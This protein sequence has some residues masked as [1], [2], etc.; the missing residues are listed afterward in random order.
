MYKLRHNCLINKIARDK[1]KSGLGGG[2][3]E[4]FNLKSLSENYLQK[5]LSLSVLISLLGLAE[6][7]FSIWSFHDARHLNEIKVNRPHELRCLRFCV[8]K[9]LEEQIVT[10]TMWLGVYWI[11]CEIVAWLISSDLHWAN[12]VIPAA[13]IHRLFLKDAWED[14]KW[15][16]Q[17]RIKN[18]PLRDHGS[19][20]LHHLF[21]TSG[22]QEIRHLKV[23]M[24]S[25]IEFHD[26]L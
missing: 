4:N 22:C 10:N 7:H 18:P 13:T 5:C 1:S 16:R 23:R 11:I 3:C 25:Q 26:F 17:I 6:H 21:H 12:V 2:K 14:K 8:F 9:A 19:S 24:G 20:W 15:I